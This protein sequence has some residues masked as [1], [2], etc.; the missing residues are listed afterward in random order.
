M[1]RVVCSVSIV[2]Q[3]KY[4]KKSIT[5]NNNLTEKT[6]I[7]NEYKTKTIIDYWET[8]YN[9]IILEQNTKKKII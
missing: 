4:S 1:G 3:Q 9:N 7:M 2:I 8:K 6:K 5:E